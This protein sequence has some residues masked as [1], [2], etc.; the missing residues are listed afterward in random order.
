[1]LKRLLV[2]RMG[3]WRDERNSYEK[4]IGIVIIVLLQDLA[5]IVFIQEPWWVSEQIVLI[6]R[7]SF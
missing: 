3:K 1:M 6:L 4:I 2:G 5:I 7:N